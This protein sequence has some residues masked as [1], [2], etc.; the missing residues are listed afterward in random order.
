MSRCNEIPNPWCDHTLL[1]LLTRAWTMHILFTLNEGGPTRFGALRRKI[2][3]ISSRVLTERLRV[4][5]EKKFI[6]RHCEPTV[7]PAV[8][9]GLTDR[10]R[11][12]G[13]ALEGLD[14]VS[15]RWREED[16]QN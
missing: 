2:R 7:P 6:F 13:M 12:M 11:D 14:R 9:Y 10:V 8:T 5:E 16:L 15:Q 1:E 3:G 4:L